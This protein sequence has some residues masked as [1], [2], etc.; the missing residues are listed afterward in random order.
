VQPFYFGDSARP[1]FGVYHAPRSSSRRTGV[2]VCAPFGQ[3][4]LRA[5][6]SLRELG[7]RLAEA[8]LPALRFDYH[9]CGDSAGEGEEARWEEWLAD[10]VAA[11]AELRESTGLSRVALI[12]LRLGGTLAGLCAARLGGVE[13]LVLWD[14]V[15]QGAAYLR[16]LRETHEAWTHEHAPGAIAQ[17]NEALGFPLRDELAA[18]LE[19]VGLLGLAHGPAR[20]VLVVNSG[21]GEGEPPLWR[22]AAGVEHQRFPPAPVW[23]PAEGMGRAF[24]PAQLLSAVTTWLEGACT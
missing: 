5:H 22:G 2:V 14:P 21:D 7:E 15:V 8:G 24:V 23:L 18:D 4:Y 10:T 20:R 17:P 19:R 16:E 9:G 3:E 11:V 12:G 1:L 6:R 13:A